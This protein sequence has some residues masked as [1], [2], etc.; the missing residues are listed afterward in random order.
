MSKKTVTTLMLAM[1][2]IFI[3]SSLAWAD[4]EKT[5]GFYT[6]VGEN[7]RILLKTGLKI[8]IGD[9]FIDERNDEYEVNKIK[10]NK[11]VAKLIKKGKKVS[12]LSW[13]TNSLAA[14]LM[15]FGNTI[16]AQGDT[17]RPIAIY[18]THSDESYQP[19][20]GNFSI[21]GNGGIYKVGSAMAGKYKELGAQVNHS[22][23]KHDP[24][25]GMA[26][27]RSRRTAVQ[28]FRERPVTVFD[29]HRDAAPADAYRRVINGQTISQTLMVIGNQ[30]PNY[31]ANLAYAR[32]L[33]D[34][35][36]GKYPGLAKG[37]LVTGGRFNQDLA[38]RSVLLEFGAHT[39]TRE[40]AERGAMLFADATKPTI[41]GRTAAVAGRPAAPASPQAA[42]QNRAAG[43]S[44]IWWIIGLA[45]VGGG[46]LL[47]NEGSWAG[48]KDK[49]KKF[50][51][52]EFTNFL[53]LKKKNKNDGNQED[54]K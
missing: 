18:H 13:L 17:A 43:N 7:N 14:E 8:S 15:N 54:E 41:I 4:E 24:H 39:N 35:A 36:N 20:D 37:I 3:L 22:F 27:D 25:D 38:P 49:F 23:A 12:Q 40:S 52:E 2:L 51:S 1:V 9:C 42:E 28:L 16:S 46:F 47:I 32:Q 45:V 48:V 29:V 5:D 6:I 31:Q 44:L 53:G 19:S 34:A 30:N 10:G 33:K 26:Y 21:R 50:T 11:A